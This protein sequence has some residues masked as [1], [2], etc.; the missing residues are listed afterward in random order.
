MS[1]Y[2]DVV[3][4]IT[5]KHPETGEPAQAGHTYIVGVLGNKKKWYELD[6][7]SL[8]KMKDEDL[9]KELFKLL[10]PQTHH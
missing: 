5:K 1:K 10:H 4:N 7:E 2:K 6:A 3:V 9:Q 8:N